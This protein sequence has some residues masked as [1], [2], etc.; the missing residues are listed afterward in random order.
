[1]VVD[2]PSR[3]VHAQEL[4]FISVIALRA[5]LPQPKLLTS[6][7]FLPQLQQ[8]RRLRTT[9]LLGSASGRLLFN[10]LLIEASCVTICRVFSA[11]RYEI[12]RDTSVRPRMAMLP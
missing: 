5:A 4:G 3:I 11:A 8:L 9:F 10:Q 12:V 7:S 6:S 2:A 1:M